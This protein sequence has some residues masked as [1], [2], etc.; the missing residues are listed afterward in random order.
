MIRL[1]FED[2][3][4]LYVQPTAI[5]TTNKGPMQA[6]AVTLGVYVRCGAMFCRVDDIANL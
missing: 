1:T 6:D 5:V 2:G 4:A 3:S